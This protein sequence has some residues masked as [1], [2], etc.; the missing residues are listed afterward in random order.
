MRLRDTFVTGLAGVLLADCESGG[1]F[2]MNCTL[3]A[4]R[5]KSMKKLVYVIFNVCVAVLLVSLAAPG[6]SAQ[7]TATFNNASVFNTGSLTLSA[8]T[9][10]AV[11]S[12]GNVYISGAGT[13]VVI[14]VTAAGVASVVN[15]GTPGGLA[16]SY[17]RSLAVDGAGD[18]YI[19][20]TYGNRIVEVTEAGTVSVV[21]VGSPSGIGLAYPEGVAVDGSGD[22]Y[23][24]DTSN[25]RI[26]EVTGTG[27]VSVV[28]VGSTTG[29]GLGAPEGLAVDNAGNLYIADTGNSRVVEVP[30]KG[31][32]SVLDTGSLTSPLNAPQ[33]VAVDSAG[34]VYITDLDDRLVEVTA[35]GVTIVVNVGEPGGK[36]LSSPAE[37]AVDDKENV[38][39]ADY[40]NNRV[41]ELS[42]SSAQYLGQAN[43]GSL[44][45]PVTV[46]FTVSGYS[47]SS[48][49]PVF[50]MNYGKETSVGAVTCTG[51]A[52]PETCS[53]PVTLKPAYPGQRVDAVLAIPVGRRG[54]SDSESSTDRTSPAAA[55]RG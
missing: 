47:G 46:G 26:V 33:G 40:G 19:A 7:I 52:A 1:D 36:A 12:A 15:V 38:Y 45:T 51:G 31:A 53:A 50:Q 16:L 11:D 9:G 44:G 4:K 37:V 34:D 49:T 18:L 5:E 48:Y 22:L 23:I 24:A 30:T 13:N 21:N 41:I 42:A 39:I 2:S 8:P 10:V 6:A 14:K 27:A 20:D 55:W 3:S 54:V 43:V 32:A 29:I 35:A 28:N 25:N 17:A